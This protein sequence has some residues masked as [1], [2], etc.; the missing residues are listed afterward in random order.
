MVNDPINVRVNDPV[1]VN[2]PINVRVN[3]LVNGL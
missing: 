3:D 2:D 1:N